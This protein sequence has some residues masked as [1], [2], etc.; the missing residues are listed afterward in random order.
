MYRGFI[1]TH[2]DVVHVTW[3]VV[4]RYRQSGLV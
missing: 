1:Y 4:D 3:V 2:N